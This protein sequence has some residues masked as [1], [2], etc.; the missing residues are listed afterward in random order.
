MHIPRTAPL[1]PRSGS[2][3]R[4]IGH[5]GDPT[6][7]PENSITGILAAADFAS[8]AEID[9]RPTRDGRLVLSHDPQRGDVVLAE[10]DWIDLAATEIG[11]GHRLGL[12]GDLMSQADD[13]PLNIEIKNWPHNPDFDDSFGLAIRAAGYARDI[14]LITSFHWP[15][16][17]AIRRAH[18]SVRTGL[19]SMKDGASRLH[20]TRRMPMVTTHW[21][22][23]IRS[24]APIPMGCSRQ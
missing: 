19:W 17:H 20:V 10:H 5:R 12:L 18:P 4:V 23:I 2:S 14:D 16:M 8:M 24:S 15:T 22:S 9:V 13:I 11:D 1:Y 6:R 3:T 7:Y 21:P